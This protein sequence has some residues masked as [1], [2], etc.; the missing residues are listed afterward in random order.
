MKQND[1][2]TETACSGSFKQAHMPSTG[3]DAEHGLKQI[4]A[5]LLLAGFTLLITGLA[6]AEERQGSKKWAAC[7]TS[8]M[9]GAYA[10]IPPIPPTNPYH[11]LRD[12]SRFELRFSQRCGWSSRTDFPLNHQTGSIR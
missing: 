11:I 5:L 3:R 10:Y 8:A 12:Q 9:Q 2:S 7:W 1:R 4:R 6:K